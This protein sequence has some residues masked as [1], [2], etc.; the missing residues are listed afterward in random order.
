MKEKL[1][2]FPNFQWKCKFK[3]VKPARDSSIGSICA[4]ST[5]QPESS[6]ISRREQMK[7]AK[8]AE[9]LSKEEEKK[10]KKGGSAKKSTPAKKLTGFDKY[11]VSFFF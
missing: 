9:Q 4:T 5:P 11:F 8:L 7:L 3:P 6:E 2:I 10:T 1:I